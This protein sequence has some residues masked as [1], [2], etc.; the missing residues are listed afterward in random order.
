MRLSRLSISL[1][2]ALIFLS[3]VALGVFG[4]RLYAVTTV[5]S[6]A[7]RKPEEF[8]KRYVSEMQSRLKLTTEQVNSL[9]AILDETRTR[10]HEARERFKPELD[11]IKAQQVAKVKAILDAT[12]QAEYDKMRAEREAREKAQGHA[13]GPGI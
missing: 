5:S 10:V 8:R 7:V 6:S 1:Y 3:G 13:S 11:T 12:Q 4:H 9:G 2:I